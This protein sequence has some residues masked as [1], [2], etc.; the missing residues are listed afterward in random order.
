M[1]RPHSTK[2]FRDG[3]IRCRAADNFVAR[4]NAG[5]EGAA[6]VTEPTPA[7]TVTALLSSRRSWKNAGPNKIKRDDASMLAECA[8]A[9]LPG[10]ADDAGDADSGTSVLHPDSSRRSRDD[11]AGSAAIR[12]RRPECPA[13]VAATAAPWRIKSQQQKSAPYGVDSGYPCI[14]AFEQILC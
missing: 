12:L 13:V 11:G 10:A 14:F 4:H 1:R 3:R 8:D 2:P 9:E 7:S 5:P 6:C